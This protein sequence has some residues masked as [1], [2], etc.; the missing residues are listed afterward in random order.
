MPNNDS[1]NRLFTHDYSFTIPAEL[2]ASGGA[3]FEVDLQL[4]HGDTEISV[5]GDWMAPGVAEAVARKS[6]QFLFHE[7]GEGIESLMITGDQESSSDYILTIMGTLV[8]GTVREESVQF[9]DAHAGDIIQLFL[10]D[11]WLL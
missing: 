1:N 2:P 7:D 8:D 10:D 9:E 11:P 3:S 5:V 4:S 6:G